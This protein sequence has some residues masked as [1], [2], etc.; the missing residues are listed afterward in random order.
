MPLLNQ[1]QRQFMK[2]Y[3]LYI[4]WLIAATATLI[5]L[6][7]SEIKMIDPCKL[8]WYQRVF[9]F[10]IP[11]LLFPLIWTQ[12][13][14]FILYILSLPILGFFTALYQVFIKPPCCRVDPINPAFGLLTFF[15]IT[16]FLLLKFFYSVNSKR[17]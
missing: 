15:L 8:C 12:K 1:F 9:L 10:P 14:D 7:Y 16:V 2:R 3:S 11:L 5:S 13:N 4:A 6:F 17:C